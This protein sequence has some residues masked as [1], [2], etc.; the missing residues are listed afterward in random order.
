[1]P[2]VGLANAEG[3]RSRNSRLG[4]WSGGFAAK[5]SFGELE[6][7]SA[8]SLSHRVSPPESGR[9]GLRAGPEGLP[10]RGAGK[11]TPRACVTETRRR[12]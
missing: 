10:K 3:D 2:A 5:G 11:E 8:G 4:G 6:R 9:E 12:A 1:L 7:E